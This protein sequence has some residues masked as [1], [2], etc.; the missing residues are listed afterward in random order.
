MFFF[1]M[2]ITK[3]SH[4]SCIPMDTFSDLVLLKVCAANYCHK[5][6]LLSKPTD[7]FFAEKICCCCSAQLDSIVH[8]HKRAYFIG[9]LLFV[10]ESFI[11][12][13]NRLVAAMH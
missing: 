5:S 4:M 7:H 6:N 3:V 9:C 8:A 1:T 11:E 2:F 12:S 13:R 10:F